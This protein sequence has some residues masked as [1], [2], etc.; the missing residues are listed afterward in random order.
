MN[1]YESGENYLERILMLQEK[2]KVV[3]SVDVAN[4]LGVSKASVSVA[5]KKLRSSGHVEFGV[6]NALILTEKG[7]AIAERIYARHKFFTNWLVALGVDVEIA[8]HDACQIE[9]GISDESF[10]ALQKRAAE[11]I[12]NCDVLNEIDYH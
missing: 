9:H 10:A 11:D 12:A 1:I 4:A 2:N 3:Y 7:L 8:K 5:M 6:S